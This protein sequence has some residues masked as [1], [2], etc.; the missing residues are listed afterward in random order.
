MMSL[1][2][3][4]LALS[5]GSLYSGVGGMTIFAELG[6]GMAF[7]YVLLVPYSLL[8]RLVPLQVQLFLLIPVCIAEALLLARS[9]R[10]RGLDAEAVVAR[11]SSGDKSWIAW[12]IKSSMFCYG[13]VMGLAA[14]LF[15][16]TGRVLNPSESLSRALLV[17]AAVAVVAGIVVVFRQMMFLAVY[18][19][20]YIVIMMGTV[21]AL[22]LS[23]KIAFAFLLAYAG[24]TLMNVTA[25]S[26]LFNLSHFF[27]V[28]KIHVLAMGIG[29][30]L[31]GNLSVR[32]IM[33]SAS[34]AFPSSMT[35]SIALS[36]ILVA[37]VV[38]THT[39][40]LSEQDIARMASIANPD[41]VITRDDG[42]NDPQQ[43]EYVHHA[44]AEH[45]HLSARE[46]DV[47]GLL[48]IGRSSRRVQEELLI[49]ESTANTH[50]RHIY[51]KM[52]VHSRQE[53]IDTFIRWKPQ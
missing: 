2:A 19:L 33:Q 18:R 3:A 27:P 49:S 46:R 7:A 4:G 24:Y 8:P 36:V 13:A 41:A 29:Y 12:K 40:V 38:M 25:M 11:I 42:T 50:I 32:V 20:T 52:S 23:S 39:I 5:W 9:H 47:L 31:I 35:M 15:G 44:L 22:L 14:A 34:I 1:G 16:F 37:V 26:L 21:V 51:E 30:L 45:Y 17:L 43:L 28:D 10:A 48:L 53:L 6:L